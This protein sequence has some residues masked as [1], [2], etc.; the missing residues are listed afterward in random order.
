MTDDT[1]AILDAATDRL[2]SFAAGLGLDRDAVR[3]VVAEVHAEA[4][5][6]GR[7]RGEEA[8]FAEARRR[9]IAAD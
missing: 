6:D 9:M 1:P 2:L 3:R 8:R 4:E 7:W 5:E